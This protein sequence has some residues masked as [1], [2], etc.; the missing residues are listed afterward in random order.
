MSALITIIH[1]IICLILI[2][3][4]L[5]QSGKAADLAGAFGGAGSATAFG[6]RG[7]ASLMSKVTTISAD[8]VHAHIAQPVGPLGPGR[9]VRRQRRN[10]ARKPPAASTDGARPRRSDEPKAAAPETPA[11]TAGEGSRDGAQK[12]TISDPRPGPRRNS[13]DVPKWWNWQTR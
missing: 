5:L 13:F 7:T 2:L 11:Q 4:V 8:P 1:V 6:P 9:Q 12:Q 10:R 3:A